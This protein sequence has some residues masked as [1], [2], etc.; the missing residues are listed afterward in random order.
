MNADTRHNCKL[1]R[2][3]VHAHL[4]GAL[5]PEESRALEARLAQCPACAAYATRLGDAVGLLH[6]AGP[7]AAPEALRLHLMSAVHARMA[8]A[9]VSPVRRP[10]LRLQWAAAAATIMLLVAVLALHPRPAPPVNIAI[11]PDTPGPTTP[12]PARPEAPP[13]TVSAPAISTPPA[14]TPRA[15]RVARVVYNDVARTYRPAP[16]APHAGSARS[17]EN[18]VA[19]PAG[20]G[21]APAP[22]LLAMAPQ[23]TTV[24]PT[25]VY[26]SGEGAFADEVVGNLVAGTMLAT[27]LDGAPPGLA[28][29]PEG[30]GPR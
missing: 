26:A 29:S 4:D 7:A 24:A 13:A 23:R 30:G 8:G 25:A 20:T 21:R 11:A 28:V 15:T 18:T 2:R 1:L 22:M 14:A 6:A 27:Y 3:Q 17:G 16:P 9:G 12:A 19:Q 5:S 10:A